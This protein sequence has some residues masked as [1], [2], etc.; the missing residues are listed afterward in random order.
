MLEGGA[1]DDTLTGR[2]SDSA[3]YGVSTAKSSSTSPPAFADDGMGGSDTLVNIE[4]FLGSAFNDFA[5]GDGGANL[6][7]GFAGHDFMRGMGGNDAMK[8]GDDDD[9]LDGGQGDDILD[10]G[11]GW[12]RATYAPSALA[13]VIVDLN[14]VGVAQATGQGNDTLL[15][16]EHVSGTRFDDTLTGNA[17]DNWIWGGSDGSGVTGNDTLTAAAQRPGP[18]RTGTH[19]ASGG[20]GIDTSDSRQRRRHHRR[21]RNHLPGPAGDGTEYRTGNDDPHRLRESLGLDL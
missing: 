8:G 2:R 7:A 16:I 3:S 20:T 1:G 9:Y 12:D 6:L 11:A 17:G 13:G 15:G 21:G 10:G 5:R 4:N 14:I 18:G 19:T